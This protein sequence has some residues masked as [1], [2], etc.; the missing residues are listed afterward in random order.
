MVHILNAQFLCIGLTMIDDGEYFQFRHTFN[1]FPDPVL[2]IEVSLE[3]QVIQ[4]SLSQNNVS[5]FVTLVICRVLKI[6]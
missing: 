3:S 6:S 2:S 1:D 4:L 5:T